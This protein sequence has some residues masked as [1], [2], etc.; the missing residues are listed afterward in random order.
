MRPESI[1][2]LTGG[3]DM[4]GHELLIQAQTKYPTKRFALDTKAQNLGLWNESLNRYV[5][6]ACQTIVN[7]EWM[8]L[9][10]EIRVNGELPIIEWQT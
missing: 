3:H 9:P 8:Q 10:Y 4:T 7:D 5:T 2:H 1:S 6:I